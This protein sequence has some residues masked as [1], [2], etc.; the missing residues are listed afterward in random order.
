[1]IPDDPWAI[2]TIWQE[3]R[4][5]PGEVK[6]AGAEVIRDR[7]TKKYMSDGIVAGTILPPYQFSGVE[8]E[9]IG[10]G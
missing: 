10:R 7:T 5:E 9:P 6:L 1:M 2:L 3:T 4:N 8:R